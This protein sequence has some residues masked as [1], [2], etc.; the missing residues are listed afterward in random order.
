[1]RIAF[2]NGNPF[3]GGAE[4]WHMT[5]AAFLKSRGHDVEFFAS[6]HQVAD[7]V[8]ASGVP[9]KILGFRTDLDP[10][11]FFSLYKALRRFKPHAVVLNSERDLRL[12]GAAAA[13]VGV[14]ARIHRKGITG[15]K[16]NSRYRWTYRYL[17][18]HTLCVAGAVRDEIAELDWV[19][20]SSLRVIY[21]GVDLE[22]FK[23]DGS[24][25]LRA[26][27]GAGEG[28]TLIGAVARLSSIKGFEY[29]ID[30]IPLVLKAQPG[31][32]CI[33]V[34]AG[35]VDDQLKFR[36]N[37]LGL[38]HK[39]KFVGFQEDAP[40]AIRSLDVVAHPSLHTEGLPNSLLEAMA[41][42]IPIVATPVAGIPEAVVDGVTGILVPPRDPNKLAAALVSLIGDPERRRQMG[43][44]ARKRAEEH[45]NYLDK[46][47]E[48]EAWL[49]EIAE[50]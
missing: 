38:A 20:A 37:Q 15:I 40:D 5:A 2:I 46:M 28:D 30:A 12:G 26:Q 27:L 19:D 18:T 43:L 36:A 45:F 31:A 13:L 1:M 48:F 10:S 42:G 7:R 4:K 23:P 16:N 47:A 25:N 14:K 34:G 49:K 3:W 39:I 6:S 8:A 33:F 9:V 50:Q 35:R 29:L 17:S 32:R 44:A 11:T 22:R 24:R 41:C 21:S